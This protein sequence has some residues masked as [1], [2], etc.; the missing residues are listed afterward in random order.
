MI[1]TFVSVETRQNRTEVLYLEINYK[2][3]IGKKTHLEIRFKMNK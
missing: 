1:L 3:I 2:F